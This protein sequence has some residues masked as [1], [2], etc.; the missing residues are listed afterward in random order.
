MF[1][2]HSLRITGSGAARTLVMPYL[3]QLILLYISCLSASM[4]E[5]GVE[6]LL[7]QVGF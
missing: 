3:G 2:Q 6:C 5:R 1:W 7:T 4:Y